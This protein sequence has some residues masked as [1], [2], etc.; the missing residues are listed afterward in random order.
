[1]LLFDSEKTNVFRFSILINSISI[2]FFI[3][4]ITFSIMWF[5]LSVLFAR[6][7]RV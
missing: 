6:V 1:M 4:F 2:I 7:L 5:D 3:G